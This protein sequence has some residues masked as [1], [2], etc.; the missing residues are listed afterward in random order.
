MT[1]QFHSVAV[2]KLTNAQYPDT[3][4]FH[5]G[6]VY[7]EY[8][9]GAEAVST[10]NDVYEMVRNT[11][12]E[13][14]LD[15]A[16]VNS[17]EW[18]PLGDFVQPGQRVLIKPNL[19]E[20]RHYRGGDINCL[21]THGS[22][23]RAV[24]DYVFIALKGE[25]QVTVGDAP[26]LSTKFAVAAEKAHLPEVIEFYKSQPIPELRV[27]D[28]RTVAGEL[29]E[30]FHVT[31]WVEG[32][33]DPEGNTTFELNENSMFAPIAD[34]TD[35]LRLPHYRIGDTDDYHK[36][37]RHRYMVPRAVTE[38]DIIIN[39]PKMKTHCK[40]GVTGAMKNFVGTV[41]RRHCF[42]NYREG[43]PEQGGDEYPKASFIK[44]MS[45]HL[46]R[47]IDGNQTPVV[48]P[49]LSLAF[50]VN[51]RIRR[52]LGID[53][54]RD[55]AWRG[56][57]T[58]WR[59]ILDLVRIAYYGGPDA[60]MADNKRRRIFTLIDGIISGEDEGPLEAK[61]KK[62]DCVLAGMNPIAT[63]AVMATLMNHNWE[64]IPTI[65]EGA[66]VEQWPIFEGS[67][68]DIYVHYEGT[69]YPLADVPEL[70]ICEPFLPAFGWR[71]YIELN[72][73]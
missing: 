73:S 45:E 70:N 50:R 5:P 42:T 36:G 30:R 53:G 55:G 23:I 22:V 46:E 48:R 35:K 20:D 67:I 69:A 71:N 31:R 56:N 24:M 52:M 37:T 62:T 54:I 47:L 51:E 66:A 64:K 3:P 57:D 1:E 72:K 9:Y 17:P 19:V 6:T 39:L 21:I 32:Q 33:G 26:V 61:A 63:D 41:A 68:N 12:I 14:G 43:A 27:L 59:A 16:H 13:L 29:D 15:A 38:A 40:A 4:P 10:K 44:S 28:F 58:V 34:L 8:P 25:G 65:R 18:N 2:T 49:L 60:V 11:F 7:P